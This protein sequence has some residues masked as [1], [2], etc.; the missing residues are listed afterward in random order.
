MQLLTYRNTDPL[1][2]EDELEPEQAAESDEELE[3]QGKHPKLTVERSALDGEVP[4][5]FLAQL[6][7]AGAA[8]EEAVEGAESSH[9]E[10]SE[11]ECYVPIRPIKHW[12]T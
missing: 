7:N 1:P 9:S 5:E 2:S 3:P 10:S 6:H 12:I 8:A 4:Y 11:G